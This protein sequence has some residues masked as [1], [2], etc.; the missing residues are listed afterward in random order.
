MN[1]IE[2]IPADEGVAGHIT[3]RWSLF[4][5]PSGRKFRSSSVTRQPRPRPLSRVVTGMIHRGVMPVDG[6]LE[7][8]VPGRPLETLVPFVDPVRQG[9]GLAT[10]LG[11]FDDAPTGQRS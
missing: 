11:A 5:A 2:R 8:A 9:R 4:S 6:P 7:G 10:S 3:G 1:R